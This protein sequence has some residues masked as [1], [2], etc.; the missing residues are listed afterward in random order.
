MPPNAALPSSVNQ[1]AASGTRHRAG[2]RDGRERRLARTRD[3][4]SGSR[5]HPWT[6]RETFPGGTSMACLH[7]SLDRSAPT[8]GS[9][10]PTIDRGYRVQGTPELGSGPAGISRRPST[11]RGRSL[12]THHRSSAM[13]G[14]S[15]RPLGDTTTRLHWGRQDLGRSSGRAHSP[16]Q[17]DAAPPR[18]P[19]SPDWSRAS[20]RPSRFR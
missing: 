3:R 13:T 11:F 4:R 19:R 14:W 16:P 5:Q 17:C 7:P 10:I 8:V 12:G 2:S 9:R 1:V 18:L 15:R 20:A 6:L